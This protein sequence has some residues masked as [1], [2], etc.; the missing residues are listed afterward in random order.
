MKS[1]VWNVWNDVWRESSKMFEQ[2]ESEILWGSLN[3]PHD[4]NSEIK[5]VDGV[6]RW[7]F[8]VPGFSKDDI[9]VEFRDNQGQHELCINGSTDDREFNKRY[10]LSMVGDF[11]VKNT[12]ASVTN[13]VLTIEIPKKE[14]V[15]PE[16]IT[17]T[18]K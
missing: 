6:L 10:N 17:I 5:L 1:N 16:P 4:L 7:K 8:D 13:G 9:S 14:K 11:D 12:T 2:S 3:K 15:T 18:V